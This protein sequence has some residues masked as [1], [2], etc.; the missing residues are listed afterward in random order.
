MSVL[1]PVYRID[2]STAHENVLKEAAGGYLKII[3][4]SDQLATI[5]IAAEVGG[6]KTTEFEM[7]EGDYFN[8][9]V[10]FQSFTWSND[11]QANSWV[12]IQITHSQADFDFVKARLGNIDSISSPVM[13]TGGKKNTHAKV[14]VN[15]TPT[16]VIPAADDVTAW[17]FK[18]MHTTDIFIGDGTVDVATGYPVAPGEEKTGQGRA[19]VYAVV[20]SGTAEVRRFVEEVN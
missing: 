20:A 10:G 17:M 7:Q 8:I 18:N 12:E 15:T 13:T 19:G 2:L 11:A 14:T 6:V 3:R 16:L 9:A 5:K 4:A 1:R